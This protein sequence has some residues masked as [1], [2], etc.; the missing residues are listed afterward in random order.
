MLS[1]QTKVNRE[2]QSIDK[3]KA[4][5]DKRT[6]RIRSLL[7]KTLPNPVIKPDAKIG[8]AFK[9]TWGPGKKVPEA[10]RAEIIT[11]LKE[12]LTGKDIQRHFNVSL[13]TI[14]KI[15]DSIGLVKRRH[16]FGGV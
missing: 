9:A 7:D 13:P 10:I 8:S 1:L 3:L 2:L 11:Y 6:E 12:G 5:L 15:K 16:V 14:W 4:K